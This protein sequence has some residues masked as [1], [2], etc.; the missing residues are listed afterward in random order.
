MDR[1][2]KP[3][4]PARVLLAEEDG[5]FRSNLRRLLEAPAPV[6]G[7]VYGVTMPQ[8]LEVVG[9]AGTGEELMRLAG[10]TDADLLIV[11]LR[12]PGTAG[13]AV[14]S[15]LM[16]RQPGCRTIVLSTDITREELAE[17]IRLGVRGLVLK[18]ASAEVLL[19]AVR[20]VLEGRCWIDHALITDFIATARPLIRSSAAAP[21]GTRGRLT[22][23]EREVLSLILAGY[24]NKEI[25]RVS[26]VTE[27]SVKHHL[28]RMYEK[29][30]VSNRVELATFAT[31]HR[32]LES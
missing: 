32:L 13:L 31:E 4:R 16:I 5:L 25:A 1:P 3:P 19:E 29:L 9:E 28:T 24:A 11:A 18:H 15:D 23:R 6:L 14:V 22:K 8:G 12:L 10:G 27:D 30:G 7:E 17:A 2:L 20:W 26:S 21:I